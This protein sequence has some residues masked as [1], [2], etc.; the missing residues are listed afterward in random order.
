MDICVFNPYL[1]IRENYLNSNHLL[2]VVFK[3]LLWLIDMNNETL[4]YSY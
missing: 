4:S 2:M 1:Y 3:Q